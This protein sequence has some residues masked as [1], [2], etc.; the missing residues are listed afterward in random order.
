VKVKP[1]LVL[2]IESHPISALFFRVYLTSLLKYLVQTCCLPLT[3][4]HL[5]P[6]LVEAVFILRAF[7][8]IDLFL[9]VFLSENLIALCFFK[10]KHIKCHNISIIIKMSSIQNICNMSKLTTERILSYDLSESLEHAFEWAA[11][12][13]VTS[14][15]YKLVLLGKGILCP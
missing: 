6:R 5:F 4:R 8:V 15:C 1:V 3:S 12:K 2:K 13:K 14:G 7:S 11:L 10:N 9:S